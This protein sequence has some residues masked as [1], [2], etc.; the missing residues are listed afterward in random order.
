MIKSNITNWDKD[1]PLALMA[2]HSTVQKSTGFT[3]NQVMLGRETIQP[4]ELVQGTVDLNIGPT[5]PASCVSDLRNRL[6]KFT[7]KYE[8][9]LI[10]NN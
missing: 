7:M 4:V 10:P 9:I 1:L 8:K 5:D 2:M 3:P 6:D